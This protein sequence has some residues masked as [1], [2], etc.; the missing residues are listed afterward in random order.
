MEYDLQYI[1]CMH[2]EYSETAQL[3]NQIRWN[4][5]KEVSPRMVLNYGCG[6]NF[7]AKC[8]PEGVVVDSFDVAPCE[9]TGIRHDEYDIIFLNDVLE[10]I[11][12]EDAPDAQIE[13]VLGHT[14]YVMVTVPILPEGQNLEKWKHYKPGEHLTY[15]TEGSLDAFFE[16]RG[17]EKVKSSYAECPP[18]KDILSVLYRKVE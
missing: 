7:L 4:F 3:I 5:V 13:N 15:F 10:H 17:F 9:Q 14:H 18:R 12:W 2:N 1:E 11:D 6:C 16:Q 8:A